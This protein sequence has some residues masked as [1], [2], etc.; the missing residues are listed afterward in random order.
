M[1]A[2]LQRTASDV[3]TPGSSKAAEAVISD[4]VID[5]PA[6]PSDDVPMSVDTTPV[7]DTPISPVGKRVVAS[8]R[9]KKIVQS[10]AAAAPPLPPSIPKTRAQP[11]RKSTRGTKKNAMSFDM[12]EQNAATRLNKV[13]H[14]RLWKVQYFLIRAIL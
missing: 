6:P 13:T 8:S 7:D 12:V 9:A 3:A 5:I 11:T 10:I 14:V 4:A 2:I 1:Y